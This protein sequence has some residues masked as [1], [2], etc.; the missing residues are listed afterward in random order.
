[1]RRVSVPIVVA[2]LIAA[3]VA[4]T[5]A[6]PSPLIE[7]RR[8]TTSSL[9]SVSQVPLIKM[10]TQR[11][12]LAQSSGGTNVTSTNATV[13]TDKLAYLPGSA[14]TASGDGWGAGAVIT[15]VYTELSSTDPKA[16]LTP[17]VTVFAST[18]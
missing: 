16:T 11:L 14:V 10:I 18:N 8:L 15:L 6:M 17:P 5:A 3:A 2:A 4:I 1:M 9:R 13:Q 12:P 7:A